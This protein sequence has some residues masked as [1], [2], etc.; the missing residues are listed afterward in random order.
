VI[1]AALA[2]G[3]PVVALKASGVENA[4]VDGYNGYLVD[5]QPEFCAKIKLLY[6]DNLLYNNMQNN[7]YETSLKYDPIALKRK[8][9]TY[10]K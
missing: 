5:N 9:W 3:R 4:V 8:L 7:A 6:T 1:A 2:A 10:Y